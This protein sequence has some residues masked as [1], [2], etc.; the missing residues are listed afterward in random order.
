LLTWRDSLQEPKLCEGNLRQDR[1]HPPKTRL[2]FLRAPLKGPLTWNPILGVTGIINFPALISLSIASYRA[3]PLA[4][5]YNNR[6]GHCKSADV[7]NGSQPSFH[8]FQT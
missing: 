4:R 3:F 2:K 5:G 8:T 7:R 6:H 1:Y